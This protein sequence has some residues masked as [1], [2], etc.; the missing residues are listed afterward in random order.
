M[1]NFTLII[2]ILYNAH[3]DI[4]GVH[5]SSDDNQTMNHCLCLGPWAVIKIGTDSCGY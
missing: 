1:N 4:I 2:Q 5:A 3:L